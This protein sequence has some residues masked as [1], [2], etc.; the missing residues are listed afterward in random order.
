MRPIAVGSS[1]G[2]SQQQANSLRF[3]DPA[4]E[5]S[6]R[7]HE[8]SVA[9]KRTRISTLMINTLSAIMPAVCHGVGSL[10]SPVPAVSLISILLLLLVVPSTV[11]KL[12]STS[13]DSAMRL[14]P[15][16][17][18]L[19]THVSFTLVHLLFHASYWTCGEWI[20]IIVLGPMVAASA[21]AVSMI[22][23]W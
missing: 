2:G 5:L 15:R 9:A 23:F 13:T 4:T 8:W 22:Y 14:S 10:Y 11:V 7:K 1:V 17:V 19:L 21:S 6:Y 18:T 12:R 16:T 20:A 3:S